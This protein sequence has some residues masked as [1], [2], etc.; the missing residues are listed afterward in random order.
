MAEKQLVGLVRPI[1]HYVKP[2][3]HYVRQYVEKRSEVFG[4]CPD[5]LLIYTFTNQEHH[6]TNK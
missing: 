3:K 4:I 6:H 1:K 2:V 5:F